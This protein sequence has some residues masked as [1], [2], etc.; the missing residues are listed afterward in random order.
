MMPKETKYS[1]LLLFNYN[2]QQELET[3]RPQ[4]TFLSLK[5]QM[6]SQKIQC[7]SF[8]FIMQATIMRFRPKNKKIKTEIHIITHRPHLIQT[9]ETRNC[10]YEE[11]SRLHSQKSACMEKGYASLTLNALFCFAY[12]ETHWKGM[13]GCKIMLLLVLIYTYMFSLN[14]TQEQYKYNF[15]QMKWDDEAQL[16]HWHMIRINDAPALYDD[17]ILCSDRP[18]QHLMLDNAVAYEHTKGPGHHTISH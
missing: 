8:S 10:V 18:I 6:C 12:E 14:K 1:I 16:N 5:T 15:T 11:R 4:E 7:Q 13:A 2:W 3:D 9:Y 17:P